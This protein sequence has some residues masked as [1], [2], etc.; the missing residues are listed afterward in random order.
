VSGSLHV[1]VRL[2]VGCGTRA[3]QAVLLRF[4]STPS[5]TLALVVPRSIRGRT[6]YL[7]PQPACWE[8]FASR[9]GPLRSLGR[10]VDKP[11]RLAFV[12]ELKAAEQSAMVR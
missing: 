12:Q 2:C 8:R 6:G 5:G 9:G 1:P 3:P 4:A 10:T 7:H 11:R